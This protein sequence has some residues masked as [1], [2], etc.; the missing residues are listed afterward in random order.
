MKTIWTALRYLLIVTA[1]VG[2][3]Y[4][5]VITGIGKLIFKDR[6]EGSIIYGQGEAVGS[7]LIGQKFVSPRYFW[8][9]PSAIDYDPKIS[10]ASNLGPTSAE[11]RENVKKNIERYGNVDVPSDLIFSSGSGLDPHITPAAAKFQAD[12]V[13]SARNLSEEEK[14]GLVSL[15]DSMTEGR[16]FGIFGEPRVNILLLNMEIDRLFKER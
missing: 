16:T 8:P 11:L 13:A 9:R 2:I 4:P 6:S 12:R 14:N 1:I 7:E 5:L 3:I 10:G 15:I